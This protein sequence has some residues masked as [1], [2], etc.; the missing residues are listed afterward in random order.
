MKLSVN[1]TTMELVVHA[2]FLIVVINFT[3]VINTTTL[4]DRKPE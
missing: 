1:N 3:Y 4:L 2:Y